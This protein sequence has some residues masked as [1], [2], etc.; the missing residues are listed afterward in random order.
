MQV[1]KHVS[2]MPVIPFAATFLTSRKRMQQY[3]CLP[4]DWYG[5]IIPL[6]ISD[7][8]LVENVGLAT[9][10][11]T[12]NSSQ[13]AAHHLFREK[14]QRFLEFRES[15]ETIWNLWKHGLKHKLGHHDAIMSWS[16]CLA[17]LWRP[18]PCHVPVGQSREPRCWRC[19]QMDS[20][21]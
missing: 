21:Q 7:L 14:T 2:S 3:R 15:V 4:W 1:K 18:C 12:R 8:P 19:N 17:R 11:A 9:L 16:S 13:S 6:P 5:D 20:W 10:D